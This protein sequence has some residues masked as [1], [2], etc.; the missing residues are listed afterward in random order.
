MKTAN[1][2]S[3]LSKKN[4]DDVLKADFASAY[5]D[6]SFKSVL[7]TFKIPNDIAYKYTSK[8]ETTACELSNCKN[9]KGLETC[10]NKV[11]GFVYCPKLNDTRVEFNYV[12]CKYY[13]KSNTKALVM[14]YEMSSEIKKARMSDIDITDKKRVKVIKWLKKFYDDYDKNSINKGLY[15]HGN[16]GCGKTFLVAAMLNELA[17]KKV[18]VAI[19]YYPELLRSLKS[20][21]EDFNDR[22]NEIKEVDILLL[23]DIGAEKVSDWNRDEILGTIL[24][25][26]MDNNKSTFF[27]SNLNIAELES[28]LSL[29]RNSEDK[30]KARR[31]IERI[32]QLTEDEELISINRRN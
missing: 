22:I 27:T 3:K 5:Q 24:Q 10:K 28:H 17:S 9:C 7:K 20:F 16:F 11:K 32:K 19:V 6:D 2:N 29:N 8:I 18:N 13:K 26:R 14:F 30:V 1:L 23:D 12:A 31:I 15:L 4:L 25:Y 21:N